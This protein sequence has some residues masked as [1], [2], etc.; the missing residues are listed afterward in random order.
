[1]NREKKYIH[2]AHK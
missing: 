2:S 1:L